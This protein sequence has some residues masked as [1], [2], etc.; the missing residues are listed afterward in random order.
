MQPKHRFILWLAM[1]KKLLTKDRIIGMGIPCRDGACGLCELNSL[2]DVQHLLLQCIWAKK[3]WEGVK[4][5]TGEHVT[6]HDIMTTS[7]NIKR[8]RWSKFGKEVMAYMAEYELIF[9]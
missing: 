2:E 7:L 3:V 5:W 9:L 4:E 6:Q 8:R 1:Q